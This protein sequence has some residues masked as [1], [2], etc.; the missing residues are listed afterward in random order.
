MKGSKFNI[1]YFEC[2]DCKN[3]FP[4]PRLQSSRREKNHIKNLYCPFCYE[5]KKTRE[6]R[7]GDYDK[8]YKRYE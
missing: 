8:M 2:P 6:I 7:E 1:S 3:L 4:L 5:I